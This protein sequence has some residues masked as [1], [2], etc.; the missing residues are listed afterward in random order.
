MPMKDSAINPTLKIDVDAVLRQRLGRRARF[1]PRALT[2]WIKG[3]IC[4][5]GLNKLLTDNGDKR[6]SAFCRGVLHDL[7][8]SYRVLGRGNLPAPADRRVIYVSN[9]PL[10]ALDGI[11][12]ID[13]IAAHHGC[14]PYFV[15]NDL[16][17]V[18]SPLDGVFVPVNKFGAQSRTATTRFVEAFESARPV[19]VF[20]SGL[21]SRKG[22]QGV[23]HDLQ[24][25]KMFVNKSI[26]SKRDVVPLFF[27][28]NNSTFFYNFAKFRTKLGLK[29]NFEMLL[30]PREVFRCRDCNFDI[31]V[32][33][34]I[35]YS[36]FSGG[37][38]ADDEAQKVCDIVYSLNNPT[39]SR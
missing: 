3:L 9:H 18:L 12:I 24:W 19:I 39:H 22:A 10:G 2:A 15:V 38:Q 32:G 17:S 7:N 23:I 8:A 27:S 1:I 16:L 35:P 5:D 30:L 31:R 29:F 13:M 26:A 36:S 34:R 37:Q 20:P 11:A 33:E 6:D 25:H 28:G 21:V 14:E 4:Q